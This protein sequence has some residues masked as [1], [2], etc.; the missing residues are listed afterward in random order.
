LFSSLVL[1]LF[2]FVL[3][4][5]RCVYVS[6]FSIISINFVSCKLAQTCPGSKS[7]LFC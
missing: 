4:F 3:A 7:C 5:S 2:R 6:F 1:S